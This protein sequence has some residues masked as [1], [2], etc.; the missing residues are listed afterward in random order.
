MDHLFGALRSFAALAVVGWLS[1]PHACC[2][3]QQSGSG[4]PG[5]QVQLESPREIREELDSL[6][7]EMQELRSRDAERNQMIAELRGRLE[8]L[9]AD[10]ARL[11]GLI[12]PVPTLSR[13]GSGGGQESKQDPRSALDKAIQELDRGESALDSAVRELQPPTAPAAPATPPGPA[14]LQ[15]IDISL[16]GLFSAGTSTVPDRPLQSLEGG[17]HDPRKRGFT[18]QNV[19]LSILGA[20]DPYL[21]AEAHIVY[22]LDPL[23]GETIVELEEAFFLTRS[24]PCGLQLKAGTFLTEFGRINPTHPHAWHWMDQPII[25]TRIFGPDGLRGPG[26]RLAWL[27]PVEWFSQVYFGMQNANG[28]TM[29]SFLGNEEFFDERPIGGRPFYDNE[30]RTLGDLLYF[31]R[32]ENSWNTCDDQVSWLAGA[33][34]LFGPNAT[35]PDGYT[36]IYGVDLTVK[37]RPKDNQQGWPFVIWESE[38]MYRN[39]IADNFV[40]SRD[41]VDPLD[42]IV[43]AGEPLHDWGFYTQVLHGCKPRWA[44]GLRYE[45][46]TGNGESL[47]GDHQQVSHNEDPFRDSRHRLAPLVVWYPSEFSRFRLQ[48]NFDYA[49]NLNSKDAHSF[50]LGAEFVLGS[51]PAHKF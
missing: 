10:R 12:Q 22:Y 46:A 4:Q 47:N 40:D 38:V 30:A 48:Y 45:F 1:G 44:I 3:A 23:S 27:V 17:G 41:P 35:G 33:S 51:H 20:V 21:N 36:Q 8:E 34:G 43:L 16:D 31:V 9:H 50:W 15:L 29:A 25:N 24:L 18:V 37:W 2:D 6:R 49:E 26:F 42:D 39:Y 11:A 32:W 7:L 28:E 14:G 19:E 13:S 5:S